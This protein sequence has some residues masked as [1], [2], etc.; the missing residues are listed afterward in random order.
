MCQRDAIAKAKSVG[1]ISNR[2][3][4]E[5]SCKV[6]PYTTTTRSKIQKKKHIHKANKTTL[7]PPYFKNIQ[8]KNFADKL[9]KEIDA[10]GPYVEI[11][12]DDG[13]RIVVKKIS[14]CWLWRPESKK[15]SSDR[16]LRVQYSAKSEI[17]KRLKK[18]VKK[19]TLYSYKRIIKKKK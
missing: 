15:L 8:L 17:C 7:N 6:P 2:R 19:S 3:C 1:L 10:T 13:K 16:L 11:K 9:D 4:I 5:L 12:T 18:K 14:L